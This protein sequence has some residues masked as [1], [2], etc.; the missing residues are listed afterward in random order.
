VDKF[1]TS[2]FLVDVVYGC[3][4]VVTNPTSS[5]KKVEVLLQVPSGALPVQGGKYTRSAHIDLQPY[6]TQTLEYYFYFPMPGKFSHYPVQVADREAV[7]A[8][9]APFVFN[10]VR[11]LTQI[12]KASWDYISQYGTEKDVLDYLKSENVLAVNLDRIAWRMHDKAFFQTVTALLAARHI[13]NDTLWS[14]GVKHD[15]PSAIRQFLQFSQPFIA[16][17]GDWLDSPLLKIDPVVRRMYEFMEYRPLVNARVGQ[18]G[19]EREILNNRFF[20]QYQR[21]MKILSYHPSLGHEDLMAV[22]YYL[23]L[24]DRVAEGIEFFGRVDAEKLTERMQYDYFTA[25]ID[26][27]RG[28]PAKAKQIAARYADYPVKRWRELFANVVNQ[29]EEIENPDVKVADDKDRTQVQT[30]AAA[31]SAS[32]EFSIEGGQVKLDYQNLDR[33]TVNYYLMDVELLFSRNPFAQGDSKQFGNIVPNVVEVV[34]LPEKGNRHT[35]PIPERLAGSNVLVEIAGGGVTRSQ[36]YYSND[37]RVQLMENYGQLRVTQGKDNAPLSTA[38][39]KVYA[40]MKGGGVQFYKDG[41]TDLRGRFD[42]SSL[43]T[44]ELDNVEKFALLIMSEKHGASVREAVP[45]KQ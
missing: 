41:Y 33:V 9:A 14:Y 8:F 13:Y 7:L 42:Y 19:R 2:E 36:A 24:Q 28:E 17:C 12:D 45:P 29:A 39:V 25:Y 5:R 21:L 23:L 6:H 27:S 20:E 34:P 32:L 4:L 22:T 31:R 38:Y 30:A 40:R 35:F 37:L 43:S 18:V 16:Q 3:H 10:V 44:S 26:F 1:V 15:D 11:E